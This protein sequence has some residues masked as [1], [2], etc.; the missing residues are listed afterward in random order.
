M[1][2]DTSN[3]IEALPEDHEPD[4]AE[5]DQFLSEQ[6]PEFAARMKEIAADK[7]LVAA[8]V[9]EEDVAEELRLEI[10]KWENGKKIWK[11]L[12]RNLRFLP[13]F[14]LAIRKARVRVAQ[15]S[16]SLA[17]AVRNRAHDLALLLGRGARRVAVGTAVGAKDSVLGGL[18]SFA[19]FSLKRKLLFVATLAVLGAA[20][21]G[22]YYA[23]SGHL[24][25]GQSELFIANFADEGAEVFEYDPSEKQELFYDN[26]RSAPNLLLLTKMVVNIRRSENSGENP[27]LAVEFFAEGMSPESILEIKA[28]EAF[29]RD[30][31][32]RRIEE[33]S[34]DVLDTPPGKQ[35][36]TADLLQDLNRNLSQGQLKGLRIKTIVLKP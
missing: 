2:D 18:R 26:V 31:M 22:I 6:D 14:S 25:P 16:V 1:Q 4:E 12:Y 9:P 15:K 24:L 5:I 32:Q 34:F 3:P 27:M 23:F 20:F 17:I 30:R 13:R 19:G 8:D 36:L 21:Y 10:E 33:Y 11:F 35:A 7:N 28:R 29:F